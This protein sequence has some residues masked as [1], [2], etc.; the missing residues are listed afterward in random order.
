L[1]D[2]D[3]QFGTQRVG[4][5]LTLTGIG[6]QEHTVAR[7]ETASVP[8]GSGYS[9]MASAGDVKRSMLPGADDQ[10]S[11]GFAD[12]QM[13][14]SRPAQRLHDRAVGETTTVVKRGKP[15]D[16]GRGTPRNQ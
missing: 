10:S 7:F 15:I 9:Q 5:E 13:Q 14:P 2:V 16:K 4:N 6:G 1:H 3:D 8:Q 11:V 12:I